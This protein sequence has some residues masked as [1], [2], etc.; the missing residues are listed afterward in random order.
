M[1]FVNERVPGSAAVKGCILCSEENTHQSSCRY[2][3]VSYFLISIWNHTKL[4]LQIYG[5]PSN[6]LF[7]NWFIIENLCPT[8]IPTSIDK[9][10]WVLVSQIAMGVLSKTKPNSTINK[11]SWF[12]V[13]RPSVRSLQHDTPW[14]LT[15]TRQS[16]FLSCYSKV[17]I[18]SITLPKQTSENRRYTVSSAL[19]VTHQVLPHLCPEN[20]IIYLL[21]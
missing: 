5:C 20:K 19:E 3:S 15:V 8:I 4:S 7:P 9:I 6:L 21:I 18:F 17:S 16:A 11:Q 12:P 10:I 13:W 2:K 1:W 14:P